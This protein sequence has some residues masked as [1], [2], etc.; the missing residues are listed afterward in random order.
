[1]PIRV[2]YQQQSDRLLI[3]FE[4]RISRNHSDKKSSNIGLKTCEKIM[5]EHKGTFE[6]G[7]QGETFRI[8][9]SLPIW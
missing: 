1:M 9:L 3:R 8:E 2:E 7:Q 4:N 5:D 6:Y